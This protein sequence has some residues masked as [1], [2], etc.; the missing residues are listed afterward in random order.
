MR[1]NLWKVLVLALC[2]ALLVCGCAKKKAEEKDLTRGGVMGDIYLTVTSADAQVSGIQVSALQTDVTLTQSK[3]ANVYE[4]G[5]KLNYQ[6]GFTA[7][8]DDEVLRN[9]YYLSFDICAGALDV[10]AA[11][12]TVKSGALGTARTFS[13][14]DFK[15]GKLTVT[16]RI[17]SS[18]GRT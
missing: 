11:E 12:I 13:G 3:Y 5:G 17:L 1:K 7:F 10:S 8:S 14:A 4:V 9:G 18:D 15:E 16:E 6:E 2:L